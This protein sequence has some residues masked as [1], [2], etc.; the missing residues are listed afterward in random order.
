MS[1]N[2]PLPPKG[3]VTCPP[4]TGPGTTG[5]VRDLPAPICRRVPA[6]AAG[7]P[8]LAARGRRGGTGVWGCPDVTAVVAGC[9]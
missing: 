1:N 2:S 5:R 3:A 4:G 6:I 8:L 9:P 7:R